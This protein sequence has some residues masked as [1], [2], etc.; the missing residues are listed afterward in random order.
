[1]VFIAKGAMPYVANWE[2][3]RVA[4]GEVLGL[5][6][7][8]SVVRQV[9][10]VLRGSRP[11]GHLPVVVRTGVGFQ[12]REID[13]VRS[14][15]P[16][17]R[18]GPVRRRIRLVVLRERGKRG[19]TFGVTSPDVP[20]A[21]G[22]GKTRAAA[23]RNFRG[24]AALLTMNVRPIRSQ[25]DYERGLREID[26]LWNARPGSVEESELEAIGALVEAYEER[27]Y[28][29]PSPDP[30]EAIK[31][32]MEQGGLT[33]ADVLPVFGT[34]GRVSEVLNRRRPLTLDMIRQLHF[35]LGIPLQS[36]VTPPGPRSIG[37]GNS[38]ITDLAERVDEFLAEGFGQPRTPK[39]RLR[40][41]G[42]RP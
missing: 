38:G 20:G 29:L 19:L 31:F 11:F 2:W 30:I 35:R 23:V 18:V 13:L 21:F 24:A 8:A 41:K 15:P 28:P 12:V 17:S 9:E 7:P 34:P 33:T 4:L 25:A 16:P 5:V 37:S 42:A 26:R 39:R 10:K 22:V 6:L 40:H 27:V 1:V 3:L 32:R 14:A 36:L